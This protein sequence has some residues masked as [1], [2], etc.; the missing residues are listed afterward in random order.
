M[1]WIAVF[2]GGGLGSM[3]RY[4]IGLW[5][6]SFSSGHFPWGTFISNL[7]SSFILGLI[8]GFFANRPDSMMT[9]KLLAAAGFCG[10]FSTFSTFSAETFELIR[11]GYTAMAFL[12]A[13]ANLAGTFLMM[14]S[15]FWLTRITA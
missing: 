8:S 13:G 7:A 14:A 11:N 15:G 4:G 12:N 1:N 6:L 2:L 3:T 10:G 9:F 5:A